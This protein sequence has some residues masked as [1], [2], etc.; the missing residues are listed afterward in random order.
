MYFLAEPVAG[1]SRQTGGPPRRVPS[2]GRGRTPTLARAH[3]QSSSAPE[4]TPLEDW[5]THFKAFLQ[6]SEV[7]QENLVDRVSI[8]WYILHVWVFLPVLFLYQDFYVSNTGVHGY[9]VLLLY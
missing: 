6:R 1:T 7:R 3:S 5:F 8:T 2:R 9:I 4:T